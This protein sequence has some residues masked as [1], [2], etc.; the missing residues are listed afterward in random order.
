[1]LSLNICKI[2]IWYIISIC[3]WWDSW[4]LKSI[5]PTVN[6]VSLYNWI[7]CES[8]IIINPAFSGY[9]Q[10]DIAS[11][12]VNVC[13]CLKDNDCPCWITRS[14]YSPRYITTW[15][16]IMEI[17]LQ[18]SITVQWYMILNVYLYPWPSLLSVIRLRQIISQH[19][20]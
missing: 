7:Y 11:S 14:I 6:L 9:C 15:I 8:L 3:S 1:M 18:F 4:R 5:K 20:K 12:K 13:W 10:W 19:Q 2:D 16:V 17:A